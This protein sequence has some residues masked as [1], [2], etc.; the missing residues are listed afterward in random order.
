MRVRVF[1]P[2]GAGL[3]KKAKEEDEE[4]RYEFL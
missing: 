2:S 4:N 1:G 3:G